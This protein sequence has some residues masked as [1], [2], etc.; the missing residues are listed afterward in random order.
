MGASHKAVAVFLASLSIAAA[1]DTGTIQKIRDTGTIVIGN[2]EVSIP[3]SYLDENQKIVGYGNDIC[4]RV[5]ESLRKRLNLPNLKIAYQTVNSTNRFPLLANGTVDIECNSDGNMADRWNQVAFSNTY[6]LAGTRF[7]A[8]KS[9][10]LPTVESLRGKTVVST[11][12]TNNLQLLYEFN[13]KYDLGMKVLVVTDHAEG[14]LMV[15]S[16]RAD[17]FALDDVLLASLVANSKTPDEYSLST[18]TFKVFYPYGPMIRRGDPEFKKIVDDTTAELYKSGE[19]HALYDKWFVKPIPPSGAV[20]KLPMSK[21]LA[22]ALA[23]PTDS[24]ELSKY[25][26]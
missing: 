12:G 2:R 20:L 18:D 16:G 9:S 25:G 8:K 7:V 21:E 5:A 14:F 3:F 15:Q 26:L 24:Y 4:V 10:N 22:N 17:A 6:F 11:A 19:M 13:K 23:T 1:A